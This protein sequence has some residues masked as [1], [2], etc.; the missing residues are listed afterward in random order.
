MSECEHT[1]TKIWRQHRASYAIIYQRIVYACSK[2]SVSTAIRTLAK[3]EIIIEK[4]GNKN[5][6]NSNDEDSDPYKPEAAISQHLNSDTEGE[7][8]VRSY[9]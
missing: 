8:L 9:Y 6:T 3:P 2:L 1:F 7:E 4:P 5:E